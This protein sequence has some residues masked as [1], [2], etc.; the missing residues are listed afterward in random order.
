MMIANFPRIL[1]DKVTLSDVITT[2][3]TVFYQSL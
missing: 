1:S 3:R 2:A